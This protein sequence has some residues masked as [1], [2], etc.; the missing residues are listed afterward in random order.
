M[1]RDAQVS[2]L[3]RVETRLRQRQEGRVEKAAHLDRR[4]T[5]LARIGVFHF[6]CLGWIFFRAESVDRAFEILGRLLT[7]WSFSAP[8]V[9]PLLVFVIG[10]M[11][12]AQFVPRFT[13][14]GLRARFS[15][16]RPA[17]Q[18]VA[19]ALAILVIDVLGPQGVAPFIY[20]QF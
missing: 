16:L 2:V 9:D 19:V 10:A 18:A 6:V 5:W 4:R 15:V 11:L 13:M 14:D 20:F 17:V 12:A 8:L 7:G 1:S 3:P